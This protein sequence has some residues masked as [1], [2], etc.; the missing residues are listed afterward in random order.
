M[1]LF[2]KASDKELLV[3]KN[4][5]FKEKGIPALERRGFKK[6]PFP[7]S[8]FGKNNLGDF[9]YE[10]CR[11]SQESH[12]IYLT[13]HIVKGDRW[14]QIFLNIFKLNPNLET[15]NQLE[16]IDGIQF[17]LPPNSL[18]EMRLRMDDFKGIPLFNFTEHRIKSYYTKEGLRKRVQELTDLIEEDLNNID[19]FIDR[20]HEIHRPIET[21]WKGEVLERG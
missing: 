2:Y 18:T 8:W 10:F 17:S 3:L 12:L 11:L 6:S 9:T 7:N 15:L 20:W 21:N 5:L 1:G 4:K 13:T 16:G 14:V 19:Y